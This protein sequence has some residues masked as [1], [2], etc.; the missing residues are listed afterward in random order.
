MKTKLGAK[1]Q[2]SKRRARSVNFHLGLLSSTLLPRSYTCGVLEPD[3][4][5]QLFQFRGCECASEASLTYLVG[6]LVA[7]L[8][9][10]A[11]SNSESTCIS[12]RC[13]A[14]LLSV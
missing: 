11:S 10:I 2:N 12:G 1:S 3:Q 6:R 5:A 13:L 9:S 7:V 8:G 14:Q 4:E